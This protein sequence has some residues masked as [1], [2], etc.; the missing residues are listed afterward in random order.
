MANNQTTVKVSADA[1]GYTA[2]LDRARKSAEAFAAT[3][4]AAAK[5]VETAQKA[6]QEAATSGSKASATAINNFVSQ[7]ARTADQAGKTRAQLLEMKAAQLGISDSVS[8]YIKQVEK[9]AESTHGMSLATTGA[10]REL[11]V[12]A[13]EAS[14]G[15]WK[16]FGGSLMVLG[17]RMDAMSVIMSATGVGVGLFALA[18]GAAGYEIYKTVAAIDAL[19]N[20]SKVTNGYLGLTNDQLNTMALRMASANGG[21]A[22]V[23]E[24]MTALVG[25]GHASQE[26]I[27]KLTTVVLQFGKDAG[28]SADKAAEAFVKLIEDP[29]KGIEELQSKYHTFSAAQIDV[30]ENYIKTGDTAK[31]TQAFI[32]AVAESQH[33]MAVQGQQEVGILTKIWL[34]FSNAAKVA[35]DNFD[36]AIAATS[37]AD[38]LTAALQRQSTAQR[39]LAQARAMPFGNTSSAQAEMDAANAQV[40]ALQKVQA[41]QQ[42]A[43]DDNKARAK[44]GDAKVAVS[45]YLDD[46]RYA[47][48][49]AKHK[50]ELDAEN[51]NFN[52]TT[53]DLDRNSKD[54][55][56]ALKRHYGNVETINAEYARKTRV[57]TNEGGIN[58]ELARIAGQNQLIAKEEKR[59]ETVLKSQRDAG[60]IDAESYFNKLHDIQASALDKEI[61]NAKQRVDVASAKKE[62]V[63]LENALKE[64]KD[65]VA[66]RQAVD[67]NLKDSIE[68]YSA[69]RVAVVKKFTDQENALLAKQQRGYDS[70]SAQVFMTAQEKSNYAERIKLLDNYEQ[71]VAALKQQY[72]SPT[73]DQKEYAEKLAAASE[74]YKSAQA[75]LE[76]DLAA[77]Q[78]IKDSY[79]AQFKLALVD[80]ANQT[81]TNAEYMRSAMDT[82]YKDMSSALEEFVTTGKFSFSSFA[83]SVIADLAKIALKAAETQL[84]SGIL[85]AIGLGASSGAASGATSFAGAFHL[86]D[87][88]SVSGPGSATSDSIPAMLSNGEFV[89]NAAATKRYSGLLA[90]INSGRLSHFANGGAVG[91]VAS[92]STSASSGNTPVSVT[93][94]NNGGGGLDEQD[95]ADL[96][97]IVQAFVDKRLNQRMRGQGGFGYQIKHGQL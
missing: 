16:K 56:E 23:S 60:L 15:N 32:D 81:Q 45:K 67:A 19:D 94:N 49:A 65:L 46:A 34:S 52:K 40:A 53:K 26:T 50:L 9:A 59:A 27:E 21:I 38:K 57:H 33:R 12:L 30:I 35:G 36:R 39:N 73:A 8:G 88:G 80:Q 79:G 25:S 75:Q 93:V 77:Q 91:S 92:S 58:A 95:A 72:E 90:A 66:Q 70:Q 13:H 1:S 89:V 11:L 3:Q 4:A 28:L 24:T 76:A 43:A 69:A 17:E 29:K 82:T 97:A 47:S 61:A 10:R 83:S 64:Y 86:A 78:A 85:G 2:E 63:A 42:K 68:K 62:K 54:Y 5:R 31:A 71:Q 18:I 6:I 22:N 44:S 37:N 48:P 84:F 96:H 20:A 51:E 87:G 55:Q 41:A 7:L 14:Q 74:Y